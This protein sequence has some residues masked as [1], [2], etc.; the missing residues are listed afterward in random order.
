MSERAPGLLTVSTGP[1]TVEVPDVTGLDEAAA[2]SELERAGFAVRVTDE[3]TTDPAQD[4]VVIGQT[5]TGG[6]GAQDGDAGDD[7]RRPPRLREDTCRLKSKKP[8][9]PELPLEDALQLVHRYFERGSPKAEPAA[10]RWLVRYLSEGTPS[11]RDVAKVTASR[12]G[13]VR[14]GRVEGACLRRSEPPPR[15]LIGVP[16]ARVLRGKRARSG[17]PSDLHLHT[18]VSDDWRQS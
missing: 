14:G 9:A 11:L 2:R 12:R 15:S 1:A 5:P 18:R 16:P 4:G 13:R 8:L 17:P 6:S 3:P 7:H 10:R